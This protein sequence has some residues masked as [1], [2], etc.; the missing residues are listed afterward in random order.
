[1]LSGDI[2]EG[3]FLVA[4]MRAAFA[5]A[6]WSWRLWSAASADGAAQLRV[7]WQREPEAFTEHVSLRTLC[8]VGYAAC[9]C[10][11]MPAIDRS[12]E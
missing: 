3:L 10:M 9:L 4:E 1:M 11:Y 2:S 8:L 7:I 12:L 6:E 5:H